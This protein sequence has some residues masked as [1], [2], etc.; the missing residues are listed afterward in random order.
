MADPSCSPAP[1]PAWHPPA[2]A[3]TGLASKPQQRGGK[4]QTVTQGC[5]VSAAK[6]AQSLTPV[7]MGQQKLAL[8]DLTFPWVIASSL[9]KTGFWGRIPGFSV[10]R[11]DQVVSGSRQLPFAWV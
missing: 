9:R 4:A 6:A 8:F 3:Q 10:L 1:L 2:W 11:L 7:E 5:L